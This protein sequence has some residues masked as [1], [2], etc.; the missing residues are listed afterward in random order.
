MNF[1]DV[2]YM[3][4]KICFMNPSGIRIVFELGLRVAF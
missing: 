3:D 1:D 4:K 2:M